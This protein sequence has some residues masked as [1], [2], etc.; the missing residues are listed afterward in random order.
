MDPAVLVVT[1]SAGRVGTALRPALSAY[2]VRLLDQRPSG[3][4]QDHETAV[5]ADLRDRPVVEEAFRGVDTLL[6]L[7]GATD[8]RAP[9][10]TLIE[11]NF[12]VAAGLLDA[13]AQAGVSRVVYASSVHAVG[14]Y[15]N[16]ADWPV[17]VGVALRPCC[18]YGVTKASV[19]TLLS[20]WADQGPGRSAVC[21]RLAL[22]TLDP[23]WTEETRAW[24]A[25]E[26]LRDLVRRALTSTTPFAVYYGASDCP[27]PR[28]DLSAA[29]ADLAYRPE[30]RPRRDGL[31][32]TRYSYPDNCILWRPEEGQ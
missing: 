5:C 2:R 18:P 17:G 4:L 20:R 1:G 13:A 32:E 3:P 25:V 10:P 29:A 31:P 15:N 14:G 23:R 24:L 30:V 7:A 28:Y 9:W 26:D 27:Q 11:Q 22:T 6:H 8:Q 16:P 21:L 12:T 19:E